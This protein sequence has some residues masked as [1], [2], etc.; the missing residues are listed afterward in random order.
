[1]YINGKKT[2]GSGIK[3]YNNK[4]YIGGAL[5]SGI[6]EYK[7]KLYIDGV[8]ASSIKEY[9]TGNF[10]LDTTST[11]SS[12]V[13]LT[14]TADSNVTDIVV[15]LTS[16][17]YNDSSK[18]CIN[19]K[20]YSLS[21][22]KIDEVIR[23]MEGEGD[24]SI[25]VYPYNVVKD[26]V[27]FGKVQ[28][29]DTRTIYEL[30]SATVQS[31]NPELVSLANKII[32]TATT[33]MEKAKAIHDWVAKNIAYDTD[34]YF[35]NLNRSQ[36]AFST[37]KRKM[38]IC[39]G[40]ADLNAALLRAVGIPTKIIIGIGLGY[41]MPNSWDNVDKNANNHAWNEA[42]VDGK[43]IVIDTTWDAGGINSNKQFNFHYQD[44]YFNPTAEEF[45][46]DH[47]RS[48]VSHYSEENEWLHLERDENKK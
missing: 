1:M 3:E 27:Y 13:R 33:D 44:T 23:L 36:D 2:V 41:G 31:D 24:Y 10:K 29:T 47:Y 34:D 12:E 18:K 46:K 25:K 48:G 22:G 6:K 19:Y 35:N 7:N 38:A 40:Y 28:N 32:K 9:S 39:Q 5:A 26:I 11:N 43:W 20:T 4:L 15:E 45:A 30:P 14:G 37:F 17:C 8:L 21:D 16:K 42:L